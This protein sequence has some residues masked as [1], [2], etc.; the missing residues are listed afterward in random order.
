LNGSRCCDGSQAGTDEGAFDQIIIVAGLISGGKAFALVTAVMQSLA[1]DNTLLSREPY[2][3]RHRTCLGAYRL[4]LRSASFD[5]CTVLLPNIIVSDDSVIKIK[6]L[7]FLREF[8][9]TAQNSNEAQTSGP[10]KS[11]FQRP[12]SQLTCSTTYTF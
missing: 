5:L 6:R 3:K 12:S 1:A 8:F 11:T 2:C 10:V 4:L 7:C 9:D